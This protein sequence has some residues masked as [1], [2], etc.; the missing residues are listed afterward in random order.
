MKK[1]VLSILAFTSIFLQVNAQIK[2]D[3]VS[4][5]ATYAQEKWYSLANDEQGASPKNNWDLAFDIGG[6]ATSI[7][8]NS[9]I[10]VALY[11]Y[12]KSDTT[13]W[14]NVDTTGIK[15][16]K[17]YNNS[18]TSWS[19]GAFDRGIVTSNPNDIGWGVYN[20]VTHVITGD[21]LFVIKLANGS[22]QKLWIK[23]V[24]AGAYHFIYADLNGANQ[25]TGVL[26]KADFAGK[27]FGYYSLANNA[28]LNREP[29]ASTNWDFTFT[30]FT[31]LTPAG[32][33]TFALYTLTG[34]LSNKGVSVAQANN[35]GNAATY[36]NYDAHTF[37]TDIN[38]IGS[39]WKVFS[40][41]WSVTDSL[42]YFVK[43]KP[44]DLWK[45]I[46]TGFGG[47]ATGNFIF[48]KEK[49][50]SVGIT[51]NDVTVASMSVYPNPSNGNDITVVYSLENACQTAT[52]TL[53]DLS[54]KVV[55]AENLSSEAGLHTMKLPTTQL[56][57]GSY[58]LNV[59]VDGHVLQQKV[60][61]TQ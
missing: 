8:I 2:T 6:Y 12:T 14:A 54:G 44:G 25:K 29:V 57:S 58:I 43:S 60:V 31:G 26:T 48:T 42:V 39:D 16:W 32:G 36:K 41:T 28:S 9:P 18:E 20:S 11:P 38:E 33:G 3:T 35:I 4:L 5:G 47:S 61:I 23:D 7:R 27:N 55:Y 53:V 52:A 56:Q 45:V 1:T 10:G 15:T 51:E 17:A 49:L 59:V 46:F 19:V 37:N 22:Y 50:S 21:S 13:G 24:S 30:Q 34:L 40:G